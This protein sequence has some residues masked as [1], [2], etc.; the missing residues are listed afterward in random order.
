M[1]VKHWPL[2][3]FEQWWEDKPQ[4]IECTLGGYHLCICFDDPTKPEPNEPV[5]PCRYIRS[6]EA[7][8]TQV[9]ALNGYHSDYHYP[10]NI[11]RSVN[12]DVRQYTPEI[13]RWY[14]SLMFNLQWEW[15]NYITCNYLEEEASCIKADD[16]EISPCKYYRQQDGGCR[17]TRECEWEGCYG[18]R[19]KCT[20]K[21]NNII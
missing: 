1:H 6:I 8:I 11:R 3:D 4:Y 17:A 13:E 16:E 9:S 15:V 19:L 10:I 18:D 5:G 12:L 21:K 14:R 7:Y 20:H 2:P